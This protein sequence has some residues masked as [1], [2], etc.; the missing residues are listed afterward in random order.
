MDKTSK[1]KPYLHITPEEEATFSSVAIVPRDVV[2]TV[3]AAVIG[4]QVHG[5]GMGQWRSSVVVLP[6]EATP[7]N[8]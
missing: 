1:T 8:N 3:E 4:A 2:C 7:I 6:T 5:K